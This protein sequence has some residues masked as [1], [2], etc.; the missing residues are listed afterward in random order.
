MMENSKEREIL[1]LLCER[2]AEARVIHSYCG[3]LGQLFD[4]F[5]APIS[6]PRGADCL[7]IL[8]D[9][10]YWVFDVIEDKWIPLTEQLLD[11]IPKTYTFAP[12]PSMVE[13]EMDY[14]VRG[15]GLLKHSFVWSVDAIPKELFAKVASMNNKKFHG[16]YTVTPWLPRI[17]NLGRISSGW[18]I[19]DDEDWAIIYEKKK[20]E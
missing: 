13:M 3:Q 18:Y 20:E 15:S 7:R 19:V 17:A 14:F 8:V 16:R 12:R 6:T 11:S 9:G 2:G 5:E 1:E 4:D 10:Q